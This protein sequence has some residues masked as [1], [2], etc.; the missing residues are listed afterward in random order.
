VIFVS[1]TLNFE[2]IIGIKSEV[3]NI[4]WVEFF[5]ID[6]GFADIGIV[7]LDY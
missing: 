4:L 6:K 2:I 3:E 7:F 5:Y 1:I